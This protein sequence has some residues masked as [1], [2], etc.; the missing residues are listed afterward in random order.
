[1][2][3]YDRISPSFRSYLE[4]LT[5]TCGQDVLT[6]AAEEGGYKILEPRGS[7]LN[8][9]NQFIH[10]HPLVRTHP[11]TGWKAL[12]AGTG[13]HTIKINDVYAHEDQFIRDYIL[14]LITRS[15]DC[16]ARMHWTEQSVAIWSNECT[17]HAATVS[18]NPSLEGGVQH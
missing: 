11:V 12:F 10:T 15:H 18:T 14:R 9:G 4:T 17:M 8:V 6:K 3:S 2:F 13:L 5:Q 1:M 16:I 7:P